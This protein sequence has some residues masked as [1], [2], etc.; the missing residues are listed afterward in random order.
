MLDWPFSEVCKVPDQKVLALIM[1]V[2]LLVLVLIML[3]LVL[4]LIMLVLDQEFTIVKQ[5]EAFQIT[6]DL[7]SYLRLREKRWSSRS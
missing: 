7:R 5:K 1:L 6:R 3:V 2:L 4:V